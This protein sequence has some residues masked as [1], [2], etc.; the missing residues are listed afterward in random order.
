MKKRPDAKL[1]ESFNKQLIFAMTKKGV[2]RKDVSDNTKISYGTISNYVNGNFMPDKDRILLLEKFLK[3]KFI[4]NDE[5]S[6]EPL[7]LDINESENNKVI[8]DNNTSITEAK[9]ALSKSLGVK[10]EQIKIIIEA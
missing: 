9:L 6:T 4:Q 7:F 1:L 8:E 10:M 5:N 3:V 2:T